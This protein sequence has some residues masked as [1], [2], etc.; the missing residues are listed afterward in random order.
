MSLS[1]LRV[2]A[3][4]AR[5][6]AELAVLIEKQGG[7]AEVVPAL[8]EEAVSP[9]PETLALVRRLLDGAFD[10]GVFLTGVG[11]RALVRLVER[12][13]GSTGQLVD[14][15]RQMKLVARGPK[16]VNALREL[17]L[18][19]DAVAPPPYTWR[20]VVD[21]AR[22][23]HPWELLVQEYGRSN[24]ALLRGLRS[25]G[26]NVTPLRVYQWSLPSELGPL[27]SAIDRLIQGIF[28]VVL[29]TT[30]AHVINL[31]EVASRFGR[32]EALRKALARV[33]V[34]SIGPATSEM[35]SEYGIRV[36]V[37]PA[38]SKMGILVWEVAQRARQ[39]EE[40]WPATKR[41]TEGG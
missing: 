22:R 25:L 6:A 15:L 17:G 13:W 31:F 12:E 37:E 34:G 32:E 27:T 2:L 39:L 23:L 8:R 28:D 7:I 10:T 26:A 9:D 5:R 19:V 11:V 38:E 3:F 33:M 18:A 21:A 1:G 16:T 30:P 24:P 35:L 29:F 40:G 14:V 4:E 41:P 20:E 36:D